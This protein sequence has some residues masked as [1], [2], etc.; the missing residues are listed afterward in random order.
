MHQ[1]ETEAT[2]VCLTHPPGPDLAT[3]VSSLLL[4]P[5]DSRMIDVDDSTQVLV[6]QPVLPD[7]NVLG[8]RAARPTLTRDS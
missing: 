3:D 5:I 8:R 2:Q 1:A 7:S 4:R 6:S